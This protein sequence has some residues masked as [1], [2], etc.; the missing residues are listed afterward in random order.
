MM[1]F[2]A[3]WP[4]GAPI[5]WFPGELAVLENVEWGGT[6]EWT[7]RNFRLV[8][9]PQA[10]RLWD[11]DSAPYAKGVMDMWD[12]PE[13]RK[14]F[15]IAP[16]QGTYKTTVAYACGFAGLC[17]KPGPLGVA[18]PDEEAVER[19]FRE[20]IIPH[21][22]QSR[23]LA[24]LLAADR[25]AERK[26]SLMLRNGSMVHG[27]WT[28]SESR[29]SSVSVERLLIDEEDAYQDKG[30]VATLEER[31][32]AFPFT[33]K[34]LRFSKP[35]GTE[36]ASTIWRDM[37]TE[38]QALFKWRAVCPACATPQV[39]ELEN[40]KVPDGVRDPK[41]IMDKRLARYVCPH[42]EYQWTDYV[43][44]VALASGHWHPDREVA[45]PTVVAFHLPSW[46]GMGMSLSKVMADYFKCQRGGHKA[47]CWFDN[48]HKAIP[49][50]VITAQADEEVLETQKD[51]GRA[52]QTV[53]DAAVALTLAVDTQQSEFYWSVYA[54]A[55]EPRAEWLVDYGRAATFAEL[56]EL[57]FRTSYP[58][59]SGGE[60]L[61]IWRAAI[62]SGGTRESP[63][64]PSRTM[65]VYRWLLTVPPGKIF[66]TKG[67]SYTRPGTHVHWNLLQKFPDGTAMKG[68]L[69]LFHIDT[70]AFKSEAVW[71]MSGEEGADP[72]RFHASTTPD[73]FRQLLGERKQFKDG[74]EVWVRV[75]KDN[76]WF[77]TL[78]LHL[79]MVHFQWAPSLATVAQAMTSRPGEASAP[80]PVPGMSTGPG[81]G[82]RGGVPSTFGGSGPSWRR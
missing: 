20:R 37:K 24:E 40:I 7:C 49:Y 46:A 67:M 44:N 5:Q 58:R 56:A 54:H 82:V 23:P 17:R 70:D 60:R 52:A 33:S 2:A 68:G 30:A 43:K 15:L 6:Y 34:I 29:M 42:C 65:Q 72:L 74:K 18:M 39:M 41:E 26:T 81:P 59:E 1:E 21:V 64:E 62:D 22:R 55:M 76:H 36:E 63:L 19:V 13:V 77:D 14:I 27:L 45:A 47:M 28:G 8:V 35:R 10:G 79:A 78:V 80:P 57:A 53:P 9:G 71:R 11:A 61:G 25:Y 31:V 50:S 38:A 48:S 12:R 3:Q 16:S 75:R 73:Y 66:A 32:L 51:H 4:G 69:K